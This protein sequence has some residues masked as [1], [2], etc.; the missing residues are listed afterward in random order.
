MTHDLHRH[1]PLLTR[2]PGTLDRPAPR[3]A[4]A[5]RTATKA[6]ATLDVYD[7]IGQFSHMGAHRLAGRARLILSDSRCS[8]LRDPRLR[9][10]DRL[11]QQ[12]ESS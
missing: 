9:P 7:V 10:F 4:E 5:G 11:G 2:T 8:R 12:H 1:S 6:R 3:P